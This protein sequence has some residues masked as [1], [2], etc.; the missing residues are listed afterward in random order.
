R[1]PD[2]L[3]TLRK[4][5]S[6]DRRPQGL[7][8]NAEAGTLDG[9][10]GLEQPLLSRSHPGSRSAELRPGGPSPTRAD[11]RG[12]LSP[13]LGRASGLFQVRAALA[14]RGSASNERDPRA[15]GGFR[16]E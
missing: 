5:P 4:D 1:Q 11:G 2:L 8:R 12:F 15:A 3:T 10:A 7:D 6:A 14:I 13:L 9:R 16:E